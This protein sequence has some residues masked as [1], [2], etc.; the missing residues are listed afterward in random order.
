MSNERITRIRLRNVFPKGDGLFA[1]EDGETWYPEMGLESR[2]NRDRIA[3][4]Y[5]VQGIRTAIGGYTYVAQNGTIKFERG[6]F[7]IWLVGD[8]LGNIASGGV[9]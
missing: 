6:I 3:K 9:A 5:R 4:E 8:Q 7:A 1:N 2:E